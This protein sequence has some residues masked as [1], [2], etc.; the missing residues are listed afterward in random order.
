MGL[1][2]VTDDL[3]W[4]CSVLRS[5]RD[6]PI[7]EYG[8]VYDSELQE[9]HKQVSER[10]LREMK[11]REVDAATHERLVLERL[12]YLP[13]YRRPGHQAYIR[14]IRRAHLAAFPLEQVTT[15]GEIQEGSAPA[16]TPTQEEASP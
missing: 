15:E 13:L 5:D 7:V 14:A 9:L 11:G 1:G 10:L 16:G 4:T 8:I 6:L 2:L 3:A 12:S